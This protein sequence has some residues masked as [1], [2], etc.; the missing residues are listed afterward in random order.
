MLNL[1]FLNKLPFLGSYKGKRFKFEKIEDDNKTILKVYVWDDKFSFENTDIS[2][3]TIKEFAF[4]TD[5]I[6]EG[7]KF[8]E[9]MV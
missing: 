9:S 3:M 7:I 6:D 4:S 1:S 2:L 5:G 8:V